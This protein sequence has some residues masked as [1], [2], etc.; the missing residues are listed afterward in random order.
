LLSE[1]PRLKLL[2]CAM[3]LKSLACETVTVTEYHKQI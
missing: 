3:S 1:A 2:L